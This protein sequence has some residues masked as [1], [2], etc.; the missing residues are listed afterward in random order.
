[1][2]NQLLLTKMY[3]LGNVFAQKIEF[4]TVRNWLPPKVEIWVIFCRFEPESATFL[5]SYFYKF[6][7]VS[8]DDV[9]S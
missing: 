2:I 5:H 8:G 7:I 1:M 6:R 4:E 9:E 3:Y